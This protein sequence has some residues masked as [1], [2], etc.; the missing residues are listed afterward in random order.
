MPPASL[1]VENWR[2]ATRKEVGDF[3]S[4]K[5]DRR[6]SG[7]SSILV[8]R[9]HLKPVDLYA[10]LRARFGEPNGFQNFLRR[11]SSDN[12]VH[13]DFNIKIDEVDLYFAGASREIQ[14]IIS[15]RLTDSD[16]KDLIQ[17]IKRDFARIAAKKSEMLHSFEKYFVFQ[18][19]Y[20]SL[21]GHCADLHAEI[22]EAPPYEWPAINPDK[23][24]L[25]AAKSSMTKVRERADKLYRASL[26]LRLLTPI[27][28]EAFINMVIL[29][30]CKDA[31]RLDKDRYRAF[32]RASI[33]ERL[34][35]LSEHCDG[36]ERRV[37]VSTEAYATFMRV[38][39]KRNFALHGNVDPVAERIETVYFEGRRPLFVNPGNNIQTFFEN[40]EALHAP[41]EVLAEYEGV[42]IFLT[43]IAE[44]L[45]KQH[46]IFFDQVISDA[47]PGYYVAKHRPTRILP[48]AVVQGMMPCAHYDDELDVIW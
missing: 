34:K 42:H 11:D 29:F 1:N 21:A 38:V 33:P 48:D 22:V 46:R 28:V 36:F 17:A 12:L 13:W 3:L 39:N 19:K 8:V 16:W 7:A 20:V 35:L 37:D 47:Y 15:E 32:I 2:V 25:E 26:M 6:P 4:A 10:Y 9:K 23:D 44:C 43:E 14:I 40:L 41:N 27:M 45:S 30:F 18:N 5:R 24:G 31:V